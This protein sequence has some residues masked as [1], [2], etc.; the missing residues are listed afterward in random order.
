MAVLNL[1]VRARLTQHRASLKQSWWHEIIP[2]LYLG[3]IPLQCHGAE[4]QKKGIQAVYAILDDKEAN[5]ISFL[6]TPLRVEDWIRAEIFYA[7]LSSPDRQLL[8]LEQL[9][10]AA[11]WIHSQRS[12]G[13]RVYVHCKGGRERSPMAVLAYLMQYHQLSLQEAKA[14]V[15]ERPLVRLLYSHELRLE[16]FEQAIKS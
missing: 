8:S 13:R 1:M 4:L 3:G 5:L 2:G 14:R 10:Q 11:A 6:G 12:A 16:E 9:Q 15:L 7:R